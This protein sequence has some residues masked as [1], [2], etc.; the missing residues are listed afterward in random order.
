MPAV[1]IQ[2]RFV[3]AGHNIRMDSENDFVL[4]TVVHIEPWAEEL[5]LF[6]ISNALI[7]ESTFVL[8]HNEETVIVTNAKK[9]NWL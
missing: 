5:C 7:G 1:S 4:G 9:Q 3:H 2:S 6:V 8:V